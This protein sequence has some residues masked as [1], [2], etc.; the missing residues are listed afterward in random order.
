MA[1]GDKVYSEEKDLYVYVFKLTLMDKTI[2]YCFALFIFG[3][4][5]H[6]SSFT[7]C[8]GDL[9]FV[10]EQLVYS[11]ME[12][13]IIHILYDYLIDIVNMKILSLGFRAPLTER[14]QVR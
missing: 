11:V 9:I 14:K 1:L 10:R 12:E 3:G 6:L 8:F 13:Y 7:Q 5:C 4:P 2:T